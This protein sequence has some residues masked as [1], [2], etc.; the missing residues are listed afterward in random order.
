MKSDL[1]S[2]EKQQFGGQH[3]LMTKTGTLRDMV[4]L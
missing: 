2:K 4:Y 1:F 3:M